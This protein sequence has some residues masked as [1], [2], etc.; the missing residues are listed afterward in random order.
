MSVHL[1]FDLQDARFRK[2]AEKEFY[3][4]DQL[5]ETENAP[6]GDDVKNFL[7][8]R[9]QKII[10]FK[11]KKAKSE[12]TKLNVIKREFEQDLVHDSESLVCDGCTKEYGE[13]GNTAKLKG[14]MATALLKQN[15]ESATTIINM[16]HMSLSS[17]SRASVV[18]SEQTSILIDDSRPS[19]FIGKQKTFI[20]N[21]PGELN[22][23]ITLTHKV[24]N[25]NSLSNNI[26]FHGF[27][28]LK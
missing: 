25:L 9:S 3:S 7:Y 18:L 2:E 21:A 26:F 12:A 5:Q 19:A 4:D 16:E 10:E 23:R 6:F 13:G 8:Y 14:D 28:F 27:R 11:A 17:N 20:L 22:G 24:P 1:V 15:L